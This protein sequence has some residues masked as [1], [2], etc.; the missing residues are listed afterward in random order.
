MS[1]ITNFGL[2]VLGRS[3]RREGGGVSALCA[4]ANERVGRLPRGTRFLQ[5][6]S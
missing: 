2:A 1:K 4:P 6:S 5:R 3:W